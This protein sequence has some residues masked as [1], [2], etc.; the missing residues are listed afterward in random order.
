MHRWPNTLPI[1]AGCTRIA[2]NMEGHVESDARAWL[3]VTKQ[4]A[5]EQAAFNRDGKLTGMT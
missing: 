5:C 4:A 2:N 1:V 3:Q